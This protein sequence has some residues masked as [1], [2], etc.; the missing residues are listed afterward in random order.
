[1]KEEYDS[2][3]ELIRKEYYQRK[4]GADATEFILK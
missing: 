1:M 2:L 4:L 3:R